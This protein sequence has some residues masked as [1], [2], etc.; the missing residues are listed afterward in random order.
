[1]KLAVLG[2]TGT[3]GEN[4]LQI[5]RDNPGKVQVVALAAGQNIEKLLQQT[6]EFQPEIISATAADTA[7]LAEKALKDLGATKPQVLVGNDSASELV[8]LTSADTVLGGISGFSGLEPIFIAAERGLSIALAN[9]ESIVTAGELLLAKCQETGARIEPVDSEHA[10][11]ADLF[12]GKNLNQVDR[13]YITASGGP[14]LHRPLESFSDISPEEAV[15]HPNWNMGKKISIDSATMMNKALELIEAFVLFPEIAD[16]I[17]AV[18]H[19]QSLVHAIVNFK[20]GSSKSSVYSPDMRVPIC[21][22]LSQLS[23]MNFESQVPL[24]E[25]SSLNELDFLPPETARFPSLELAKLAHDKGQAGRIAL[26]AANEVFVELFIKNEISFQDIHR[27][28]HL[29]LKELV[30]E[31]QMFDSLLAI[32]DYDQWCRTESLKLSQKKG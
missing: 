20:D 31:R 13:A 21:M 22:A 29:S 26:N 15:K 17:Q 4:T 19:P 3:I 32:K 24:L 16:S 9:K 1:M 25:P 5:A 27:L 8:K 18:I 12:R 6:I 23:G 28:N 30:G 14:F 2:S 10:S 7:S 11:L